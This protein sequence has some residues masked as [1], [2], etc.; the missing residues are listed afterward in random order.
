MNKILFTCIL[1]LLAIDSQAQDVLKVQ[2]GVVLSTTGG[3]TI[4]LND[5]D[6]DNDGIFNQGIGQ[7][8]LVFKGTA[9]NSISGS[10]STLFNVLQLSKTGSGKLILQQG[11]RIASAIA[12]DKGN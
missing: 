1:C 7:G 4:T 6:F 10:S 8:I 9:A 3:V 5:M 11:I 12:F 2:S